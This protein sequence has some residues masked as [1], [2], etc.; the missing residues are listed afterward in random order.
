MKARSG[1]VGHYDGIVQTEAARKRLH[2]ALRELPAFLSAAGRADVLVRLDASE[3][4]RGV[5]EQQVERFKRENALLRNSLRYL[6]VM[7]GELDADAAPGVNLDALRTAAA[8]V[9]RDELLLQAGYDHAIAERV[10]RELLALT[11]RTLA[12]PTS[13]RE[14]LNTLLVHAKVVRERAPI[15]DALTRAIVA[16]PAVSDTQA[17]MAG[18]ARHQRVATQAESEAAASEVLLV[19]AALLL[20]AA[21]IIDRLRRSAASLR[22]A[23][24]KL[25]QA[26]ASLRVEQEKQR[27]LSDLKSRFVSMTSH[28]FRTPLSVIMSSSEMLEAYADKWS[29]EKKA[30]HFL[31]IRTAALGMT[32][33]LDAILMIGR[34]DSG[35]LAFNPKPLLIEAFCVDVV[36]AV[37]HAS[38]QPNRVQYHGPENSLPVPADESLLRHVLQN[39]LSN[40][41]KYSPNGREVRFD[42]TRENGWLV[43]D[44]R[45]HGIG[46]SAEDQVHLF[47]TFHRGSNVGSIAGTGLG[48]AIVKRAVELHGGT[49]TL[50][51]E[52]GVGSR[53][54]VRIPID[55]EST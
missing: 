8:A 3:R 38:K 23:G 9:V 25:E 26:V 29:I 37:S 55:G 13:M 47:E 1:I 43:F 50:H 48:L 20:G 27:E 51:S 46:I 32:E 35:V 5:L 24:T 12:A 54:T 14:S 21:S 7:A 45:D 28:E 2:R 4:N 49:L 30:E 10:D 31:R 53:F 40:A 17:L 16:G 52:L 11:S 22:E 34:S 41:L 39:L 36:E 44:V 6:P 15:V 18:F 33:M 42:V 19:I